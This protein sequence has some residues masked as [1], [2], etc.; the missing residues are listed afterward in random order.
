M[1]RRYTSYARAL[2]RAGCG[3]IGTAVTCLVISV[4]SYEFL[5][6]LEGNGI[7]LGRASGYLIRSLDLLPE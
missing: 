6:V 7:F 3:G 1:E 5:A 4:S 2:V